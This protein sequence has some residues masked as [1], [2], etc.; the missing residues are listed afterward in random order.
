MTRGE[1]NNNPCN[2]RISPIAWKG[3]VALN[4]DGA[5]EQ[6][7][8]AEDGIRAGAKILCNY[9]RL[10]GLQTVSQLISRWAPRSEND[11]SS[12]IA[13]VARDLGVGPNDPLDFSSV[14]IIAKLVT[15]VIRHENGDQPYDEGLIEAACLQAIDSFK[16]PL[17]S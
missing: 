11:T 8:N 10:Y 5:F 15:A 13:C 14:Q 1:R 16:P 12:Y 4:T 17:V 2:I 9:Y 3:K 7:D 6:F